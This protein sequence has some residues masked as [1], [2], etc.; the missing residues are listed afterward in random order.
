MEFDDEISVNE[1]LRKELPTCEYEF[2]HSLNVI[3]KK[4]STNPTYR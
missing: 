2:G 4:C 3:N 1:I